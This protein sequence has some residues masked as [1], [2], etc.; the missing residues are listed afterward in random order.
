VGFIQ[1]AIDLRSQSLCARHDRHNRRL[2]HHP[3]RHPIRCIDLPFSRRGL[4][5]MR[6]IGSE[7]A[8]KTSMMRTS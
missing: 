8:V 3:R 5:V 1:F 4:H 7:E 6:Q 2:I